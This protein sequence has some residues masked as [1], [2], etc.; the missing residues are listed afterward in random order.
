MD[1]TLAQHF[2]ITWALILAFL[3]A[4]IARDKQ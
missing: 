3:P 1:L 2:Y 4:L